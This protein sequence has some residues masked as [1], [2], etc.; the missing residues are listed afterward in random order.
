MAPGAGID[1][2][3]FV[4][5]GRWESGNCWGCN[6]CNEWNRPSRAECFVG[7]CNGK[8]P[9]KPRLLSN[10]KAWKEKHKGQPQQHS[11]PARGGGGAQ[12]GGGGAQS[13]EVKKLKAELKKANESIAELGGGK[14]DSMAVDPAPPLPAQAVKAAQ[15]RLRTFDAYLKAAEGGEPDTADAEKR[16]RLAKVVDDAKA[17]VDS[18]KTAV[19]V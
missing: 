8:K 13:A 6:V 12:G 5:V 9:N 18:A 15:A 19:N 17:T 1:K 2:D 3:G 4:A 11:P 7:C 10:T 14:D 16:V